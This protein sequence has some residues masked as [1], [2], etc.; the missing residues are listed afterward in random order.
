MLENLPYFVGKGLAVVVVIGKSNLIVVIPVVYYWASSSI[1][2][3][4]E[5][6][7]YGLLGSLE[8]RGGASGRNRRH[9]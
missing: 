6:H 2:I 8:G 3:A 7:L 9:W 5:Q 1:F 4:A